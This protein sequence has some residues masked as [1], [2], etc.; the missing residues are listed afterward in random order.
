LSRDR[1]DKS[2]LDTVIEAYKPGIDRTLIQQ[3]LRLTVEERVSQLMELQ[4]QADEL[5][6]AGATLSRP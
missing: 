4:R 2:T 1:D 3:N 5:R 6:K